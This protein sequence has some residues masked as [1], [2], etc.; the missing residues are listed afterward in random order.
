VDD[1]LLPVAALGVQHVPCRPADTMCWEGT[2]AT[3]CPRPHVGV[4]LHDVYDVH[5]AVVP[6]AQ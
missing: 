4:G 2:T 1:V 3:V 6:V 5:A